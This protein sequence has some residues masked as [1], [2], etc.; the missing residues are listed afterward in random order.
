MYIAL[1]GKGRVSFFVP[2][3]EADKL[4]VKALTKIILSCLSYVFFFKPTPV[5]SVNTLSKNVHQKGKIE[6]HFLNL[7]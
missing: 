5:F 6:N 2:Q 7:S 1:P 3:K 4:S